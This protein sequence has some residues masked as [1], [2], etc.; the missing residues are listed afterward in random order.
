M[1]DDVK[2][3]FK[4]IPWK[5]VIVLALL[6]LLRP[7]LSILGLSDRLGSWAPSAVTVIVDIIWLVTAI[8]LQ[9]KQPILTLAMAGLL[10]G[11]LSTLLAISIQVAAQG[12]VEMASFVVLAVGVLAANVFING[13]WGALLGF[14][15]KLVMRMQE[16]G[17][18]ALQ[19]KK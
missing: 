1:R 5:V 19:L 18:K 13:V 17:T 12:G 6:L 15:A 11:V 3:A 9:L 10:Y 8:K 4:A 2:Q 14:L 7:V 16:K